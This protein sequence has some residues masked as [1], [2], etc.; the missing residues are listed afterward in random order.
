MHLLAITV[1]LLSAALI[2]GC[3]G[4]GPGLVP[5]ADS[6]VMLPSPDGGVNPDAAAREDQG[7]VALDLGSPPVDLG[8]DLG[9]VTD[10]AVPADEG[11]PVDHGAP[12]DQGVPDSGHGMDG[13][14][15]GGVDPGPDGGM[16]L[17]APAT[18]GVVRFVALGDGGEGNEAQY[19]VGQAMADLCCTLGCDLALY[20]GDNFYDD[21]VSSLEDMQFD[22]KFELPYADL[23]IPFYVVLGNHDSGGLGG[24]GFEFWRGAIQVDY[25]N[26]SDK[27]TMP[28][29]YY[30]FVQEH[31]TFV[32]LDTNALMWGHQV[33]EQREFVADTID[34]A[35]TPWVIAFGHHPYISN[36]KHGDAGAY[37]GI[38]G[39]PI[40]SGGS[41]KSFFDDEICGRVDLYFSGHDHN[42]QWLP[43]ACDTQLVVSGAAAKTT[44]FRERAIVGGLRHNG[45]YNDDDTAGFFWG[46]IDGNT[47]RA[48]FYDRYGTLNFETT[49]TR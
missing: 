39:I 22:T 43:R 21:G 29:E 30:A 23:D 27:W 34:A 33:S 2:I 6:D 3:D 16:S 4:G 45:P 10:T 12:P 41:V 42:R 37:E 32:G 49:M 36:G 44:G 35:T 13:G 38:P 48:R 46:E 17:C 14:T 47:L 20:L 9:D 19:Q 31:V 25:T 7:A 26:V 8:A 18:P 40:L 1:T 5:G 24:A 28:N 15:D 11:V